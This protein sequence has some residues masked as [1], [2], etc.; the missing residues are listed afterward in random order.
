[1][2]SS[3]ILP[4]PYPS[5]FTHSHVHTH[6]T[7]YSHSTLPYPYPSLNTHLK[8]P[9]HF[10]TSMTLTHT[11][12]PRTKPSLLRSHCPAPMF[13]HSEMY[14]SGFY[15]GPLQAYTPTL[16]DAWSMGL[17]VSLSPVWLDR[18]SNSFLCFFLLFAIRSHLYVFFFNS[19]FSFS[20]HVMC[21]S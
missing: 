2:L 4:C 18:T 5:H 8:T 21:L 6:H 3:S 1:M 11:T 19:C 12:H 16:V 13:S 20:I 17:S 15:T 14:V 10:H 9:V 7:T